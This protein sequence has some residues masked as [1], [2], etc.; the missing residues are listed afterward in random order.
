MVARLKDLFWQIRRCLSGV[1][2]PQQKPLPFGCQRNSSHGQVGSELAK[3][4]GLT[5]KAEVSLHELS[6]ST[7]I[8]KVGVVVGLKGRRLGLKGMK[9]MKGV[10]VEDFVF[11]VIFGGMVTGVCVVDC[12]YTNV[13]F[14]GT[15]GV[16]KRL[17]WYVLHIHICIMSVHILSTHIRVWP[18]LLMIHLWKSPSCQSC[19]PI[20]QTLVWYR[21]W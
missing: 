20:G 3:V 13:L 9:G 18:R 6:S 12:W 8:E 19:L 5:A 21:K 4:N 15:G 7:D 14:F 17:V 16:R 2:A 11:W 1:F 10:L